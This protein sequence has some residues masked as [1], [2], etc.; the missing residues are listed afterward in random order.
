MKSFYGY[1]KA[2]KPKDQALRA[3]Q[4]DLIQA[5]S[6]PYY[7]APFELIGDWK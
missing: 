2:G 1:L 3:A 4:V 5:E 6:H 7:W